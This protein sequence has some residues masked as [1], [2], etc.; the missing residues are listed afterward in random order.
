MNNVVNHKNKKIIIKKVLKMLFCNDIY[1]TLDYMHL[2]CSFENTHTHG[3]FSYTQY[4][5]NHSQLT[6]ISPVTIKIS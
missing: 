1:L 6:I 2:K 3:L 4:C 5:E